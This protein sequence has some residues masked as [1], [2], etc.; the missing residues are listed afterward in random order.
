MSTTASAPTLKSK[1]FLTLGDVSQEELMGLL[2]FAAHLKDLRKRGEVYAPLQGKSV[3]MYFEKPSNRTRVSFEVGLNDLGAHPIFL[4]KEEINLGVRETIADTARTL[5]RYV[6]SIIIRTFD[7]GEVE[8]LAHYATVPVINALTDQYHPCQIVADLLTFKEKFGDFK[9]KKLCYL[10]DGN[11]MAH[12]LLLGCATVGM[13][14]SIGCP[15]D[16][17]PLPKIVEKAKA[18]AKETGAEIEVTDRITHA[19][20]GAH[21]VYTDVWVSMGQ[22][23]TSSKYDVFQDYQVN[24]EIMGKADPNAIVLHCLPAHRGEEI[25]GNVFEEHAETIFDQAENRLH[26]QKAVLAALFKS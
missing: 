8:E 17:I 21:A 11:N 22:E 4:R 25:C 19:V 23:S 15:P 10:G 2:S 7:Q 6:D 18:I 16:Y 1:H 3:A 14:I 26:G 5:S 13:S 12:S 9:G 20:E 24:K